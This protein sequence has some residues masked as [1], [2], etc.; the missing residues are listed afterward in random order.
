MDRLDEFALLLAI[1]ER[2]SLSGAARKTGRSPAA[3]TRILNEMEA[4]LRVRL[5]E[6]TT[7]RLAPTDAGVRLA[8][9]ARRVLG[10]YEDSVQDVTGMS[11]APSGVLRVTA[12]LLFGRRHVAPLIARFLDQYPQMR[13]ELLLTNSIVDLIEANIDV[14][15]RIDTMGASNL[16]ARRVGEMR[17]VVVASPAYL[18]RRGEPKTLAALARTRP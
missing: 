13:A 5:V 17:R 1:I 4:R 3:V 6:R 11:G 18:A 14:A 2:G 8:E 16:V 12:P 15:V 10:D 9:H 7:R